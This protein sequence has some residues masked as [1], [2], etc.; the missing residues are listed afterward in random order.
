LD[1]FSPALYEQITATCNFS[2]KCSTCYTPQ[3]ECAELLQ[4]MKQEVGGYDL[5]NIYDRCKLAGD[6]EGSAEVRGLQALLGGDDG[7]AGGGGGGGDGE[8]RTAMDGE[9]AAPA[10]SHEL[11]PPPPL[12]PDD[13][14][15]GEPGVSILESVY[16]D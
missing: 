7:H 8:A 3:A 4:R 6:D 13:A 5:Y 11:E 14:R 1:R 2:N 9:E 16:F 10:A 12:S 15:F